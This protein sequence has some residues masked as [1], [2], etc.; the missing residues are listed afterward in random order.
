MVVVANFWMSGFVRIFF[1]IADRLFLPKFIIYITNSKN[2]LEAIPRIRR[3]IT[4]IDRPPGKRTTTKNKLNEQI[5]SID[6]RTKNK[7]RYRII[8]SIQV[9]PY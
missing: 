1:S 9:T 2:E 3:I 6:A 4:I 8:K 7:I 5:S